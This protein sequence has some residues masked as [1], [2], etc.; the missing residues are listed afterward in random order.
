M[1]P[2]CLPLLR[3]A[4]AAPRGLVQVAVVGLAWISVPFLVGV[5]AITGP[6]G[7]FWHFSATSP[8]PGNLWPNKRSR[9]DWQRGPA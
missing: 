8:D 7:T 9:S 6:S 2:P 4:L 1:A 5:S 3:A